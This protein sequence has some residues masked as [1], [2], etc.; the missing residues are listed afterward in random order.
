MDNYLGAAAHITLIPCQTPPSVKFPIP[1]DQQMA[2]IFGP[3]NVGR[4]RKTHGKVNKQGE[5]FS[6]LDGAQRNPGFVVGA[7]AARPHFEDL[8]PRLMFRILTAF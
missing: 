5:H 7:R 2:F 4:K 8:I 3:E 6:R 1:R